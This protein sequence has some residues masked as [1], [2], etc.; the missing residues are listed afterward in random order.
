M[1]TWQKFIKFSKNEGVLEKLVFD[2]LK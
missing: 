2:I 1:T